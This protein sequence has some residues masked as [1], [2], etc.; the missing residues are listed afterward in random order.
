MLNTI[1]NEVLKK[2]LYPWVRDH[3]GDSS[4]TF[5]QDNAPA[6]ASRSTNEWCVHELPGFISPEDWPS[7]PPDLNPMDKG[8]CCPTEKFGQSQV[9]LDESM[10]RNPCKTAARNFDTSKC[11]RKVFA[12]NGDY[13]ED[14]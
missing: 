8:L 7:F 12:T 11:F 6:H 3:I 2:V 1:K 5:Q 9:D 13:F 4:W 14:V 10:G